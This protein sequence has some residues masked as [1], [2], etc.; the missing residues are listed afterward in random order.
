MTPKQKAAQIYDQYWSDVSR[1]P[2]SNKDPLPDIRPLI[3]KAIIEAEEAKAK[4]ERE[5]CAKIAND[6][7]MAHL[8]GKH[9]SEI[10]DK[11]VLHVVLSAARI[12][13]A[14]RAQS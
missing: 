14:I 11:E 7:V 9:P 10:E 13:D 5:A 12:R 6:V 3:E 1:R 4:A 2:V 8:Q